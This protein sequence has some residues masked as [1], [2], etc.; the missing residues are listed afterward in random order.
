MYKDKDTI[1]H[2]GSKEAGTQ[3]LAVR[4]IFSKKAGTSILS[5]SKHAKQAIAEE[6]KKPDYQE[7]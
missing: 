7:L 4:L 6:L 3:K 1:L 5:A 2:V